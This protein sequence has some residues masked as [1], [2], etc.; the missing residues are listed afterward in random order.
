MRLSGQDEAEFKELG[1]PAARHRRDGGPE[2]VFEFPIARPD[3]PVALTSFVGRERDVAD[4][5]KLLDEARLLT[6]T[7]VGGCGKTR[8]AV[9]A[10]QATSSRFAD[11][12]WLVE[13]AQLT[14][15][16]LVPQALGAVFGVREVPTQPLLAT[17][18]SALKPR[19]LLLVLDNCE[20]LLDGCARL[21]DA[22][23]RA[24]APGS[25]C[26]RRAVSRLA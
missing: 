10:A 21:V 13:L 23:L 5:C 14:D 16:A 22:L 17:L 20:H 12:A 1:Q 11:G 15:E 6:L 26:W 3:L 2:H 8:L 19:R 25:R 9:E 18:V 7:G 4:V 24:P